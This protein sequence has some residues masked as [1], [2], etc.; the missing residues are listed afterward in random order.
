[1]DWRIA[2]PVI[3]SRKKEHNYMVLLTDWEKARVR[4][5]GIHWS[6]S[7]WSRW[8]SFESSRTRSSSNPRQVRGRFQWCR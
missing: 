5:K 4:E 6:S 7:S 3:V 2:K 1:M 8:F